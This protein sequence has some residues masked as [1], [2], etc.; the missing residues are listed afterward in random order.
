MDHKDYIRELEERINSLEN[1][2][3]NIILGPNNNITISSCQIESLTTG[4]HCEF[5][6]TSCPI[7]D[8]KIGD[9][10]SIKVH[11]CP[12]G[13]IINCDIE[14]AEERVDELEGRMDKLEARIEDA[15]NEPI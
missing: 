13:T 10:S 4:E 14:E 9:N 6:F 11:N 8:I 5:N 1:K 3:S 12:T 2:L 7:G 15:S